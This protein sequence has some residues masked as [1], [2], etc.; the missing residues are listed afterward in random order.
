MDW[1]LV[2][3]FMSNDRTLHQSVAERM[4]FATGIECREHY[5]SNKKNI[6]RSISVSIL[7]YL[8]QGMGYNIEWVD[9]MQWDKPKLNS[10]T[11][12]TLK[13]KK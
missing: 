8:P 4:P 11:L 10:P 12:D 5:V 9:C 3:L 6:D 7:R 2:V 13:E 1:I